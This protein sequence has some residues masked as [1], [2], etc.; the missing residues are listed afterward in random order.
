MAYF[1]F[2]FEDQDEGNKTQMILRLRSGSIPLIILLQNQSL[3]D[4][5]IGF[6]IILTR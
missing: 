6:K 1:I 5:K 3:I 4:L 2:A